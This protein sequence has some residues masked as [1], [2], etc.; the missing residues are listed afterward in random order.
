[1]LSNWYAALCVL[2]FFS[3]VTLTI[4]GDSVL[5]AALVMTPVL[6]HLALTSLDREVEERVRRV[7]RRW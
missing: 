7:M 3:F 4:T 6:G 5:L 2:M 1:M